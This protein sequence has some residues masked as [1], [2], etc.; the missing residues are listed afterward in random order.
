MARRRTLRALRLLLLVP[1]GGCASFNHA[2]FEVQERAR[3]VTSWSA[4]VSVRLQGPK[5]RVR[6]HTLVA[7]RKPSELRVELPA[8]TG[9][10]LVVVAKD[11]VVTA[12]FP[13]ERAVYRGPAHADAFGALLGLALEPREIMDLLLGEAAP[14][15][16]DVRVG[17][18]PALPERIEV[19]LPDGARLSAR[20]EAP[21][22][23]R[24]LGEHAFVPPPHEGFRLLSVDEARDFLGQL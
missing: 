8:P 5:I 1:C 10:R 18:G 23:G 4:A 21:E 9:P 3:L 17:W 14:R 13:R 15:L 22:A 7:F 20:V 12:V 6:A 19:T 24:D 2:S 11:D 16:R